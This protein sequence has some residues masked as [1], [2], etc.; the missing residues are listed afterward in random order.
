MQK[1][2][3]F[4]LLY[5]LYFSCVDLQKAYIEEIIAWSVIVISEY[6]LR[7]FGKQYNLELF[8]PNVPHTFN[9]KKRLSQETSSNRYFFLSFKGHEK[10]E[11]NEMGRQDETKTI[12][13]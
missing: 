1:C 7:I 8:T 4:V 2:F 12:V 5:I 10:E 11:W 9:D 6:C 3:L 13:I